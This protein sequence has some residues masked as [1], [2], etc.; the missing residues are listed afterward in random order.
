MRENAVGRN[1]LCEFERRFARATRPKN[2]LSGYDVLSG[3][4]VDHNILE[5]LAGK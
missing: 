1:S 2:A 4:F 3:N 5:Q